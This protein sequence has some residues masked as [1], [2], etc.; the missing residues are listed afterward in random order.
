MFLFTQFTSK[1]I[2]TQML[3]LSAIFIVINVITVVHGDLQYIRLARF[4]STLAVF[5]FFVIQVRHYSKWIYLIYLLELCSS[6]GFTFYALS[7]GPLIF[8]FSS[9][10]LYIILGLWVFKSIQWTSIKRYEYIIFTFMFLANTCFFIYSI[11]GFEES[12]KSQ[13]EFFLI[14][15]TGITG[16]TACFLSGLS[17]STRE[18]FKSTYFLFAIFAFVFADFSAMMA[19]YYELFP[20]R[21]FFLERASYLF[22]LYILTRFCYIDNQ[23]AKAEETEDL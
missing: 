22:G 17:N 21:F 23:G 14:L 7:F 15:L 2:R 10:P 18:S 11:Y 3:I 4:V 6:I 12:L 1:A 5:L 16:M 9:V 13:L 19:H 8:L 20:Q